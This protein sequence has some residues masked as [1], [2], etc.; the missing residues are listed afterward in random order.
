MYFQTKI[1][2]R[3]DHFC[4]DTALLQPSTSLAEQEQKLRDQLDSIHA[5]AG[6]SARNSSAGTAAVTSTQRLHPAHLQAPLAAA[7]AEADEDEDEED[8]AED[9]VEEEGDVVEEQTPSPEQQ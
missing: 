6:Q 4:M 3:P 9:D 5:A 1:S 8:I 2:V 7:E